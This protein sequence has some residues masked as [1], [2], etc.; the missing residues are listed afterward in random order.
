MPERRRGTPNTITPHLGL[1][2]LK[3]KFQKRFLAQQCKELTSCLGEA[4]AAT[5]AAA[6]IRT[7]PYIRERKK[8]DDITFAEA[9]WEEKLFWSWKDPAF[10]TAP[11]RRLVDY[12]VNLPARRSDTDWGEIDL[13]GVSDRNLPLVVELKAPGSTESPA[14]MLVQATAYGV[15]V[16]KAWRECLRDEWAK[17]V[18]VDAQSLPTELS[19]CQLV[20]AA[21]TEYWDHW[22]GNTPRA[23]TVSSDVW[24][25]IAEL[26]KSLDKSGYP[27]TFVR[28]QHEG[29]AAKPESIRPVEHLLPEG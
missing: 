21:P 9:Q 2:L 7:T 15:A 28:L 13:L 24:A 23:R 3:R 10:G 1:H 29:T 14:Q 19:T 6:P 20:C 11:W 5:I 26:R 17:I 16:R 27:S 8:R 22:T 25:A 4:L 12:Q 18:D